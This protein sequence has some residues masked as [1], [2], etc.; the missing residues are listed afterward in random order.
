M[1]IFLSDHL[2]ISNYKN[3]FY[4]FI[5]SDHRPQPF[6]S[7][8]THHNFCGYETVTLLFSIMIT[9]LNQLAT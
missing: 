9:Y 8:D 4:L 3:I 5:L 1:D 2:S 6:V 7:S